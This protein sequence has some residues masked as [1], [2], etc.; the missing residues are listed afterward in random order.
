[1]AQRTSQFTQ[2]GALP[3]RRSRP[4]RGPASPATRGGA[5]SVRANGHALYNAFFITVVITGAAPVT[6]QLGHSAAGG[7]PVRFHRLRHGAHQRQPP[8]VQLQT[9]SSTHYPKHF[10]DLPVPV[11]HHP[12][13]TQDRNS[14]A[15]AEL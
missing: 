4:V 6:S 12:L 13:D 7:S 2:L 1:M 15:D 9:I 14:L 11:A 3:R 10:K 8:V 5:R